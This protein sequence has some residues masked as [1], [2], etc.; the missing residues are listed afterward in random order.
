MSE[1]WYFKPIQWSPEDLVFME[2]SKEATARICDQIAGLPGYSL[3][4]VLKQSLGTEETCMAVLE[5]FISQES[6]CR[7]EQRHWCGLNQCWHRT[8]E[9]AAFHAILLNQG[10]PRVVTA[11]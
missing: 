7:A 1:P 10:L 5:R 6:I 8:K 2:A 11:Q 4:A 3:I 9:G